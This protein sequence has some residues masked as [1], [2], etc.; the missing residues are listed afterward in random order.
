MKGNIV[1]ATLNDPC[2][3]G[4]EARENTTKTQCALASSAIEQRKVT[5]V[6]GRKIVE[7]SRGDLH[8]VK[9]PIWKVSMPIS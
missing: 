2:D 7:G 1:N 8:A 3:N 4:N 6:S 9:L 5:A